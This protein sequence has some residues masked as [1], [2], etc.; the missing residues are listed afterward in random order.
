MAF[1]D[2]YKTLGVPVNATESDIKKKFR[3]LALRY[4][5]DKNAESDFAAVHFREIQEAYETLTDPTRRYGY[6]REWRLHFP[7]QSDHYIRA[8]TPES[9]LEES[10]QLN[11]QVREMDP[12]R[13]NTETVARQVKKVLSDEHIELLLFHKNETINKSIITELMAV[14]ARLHYS[15]IAAISLLLLKLANNSQPLTSEIAEWR[16]Q[17]KRKRYWERSYPFIAIGLALLICVLIYLLS[18]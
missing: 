1:K 4:H 15:Q 3:K 14:A 2:H 7:R 5:P 9:I 8:Y 10:I 13:M 6:D 16:Q 11:K 17:L 18:R 12:Y